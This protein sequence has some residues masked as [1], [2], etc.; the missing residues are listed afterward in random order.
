M[1]RRARQPRIEG[2]QAS[3]LTVW[4]PSGAVT[5]D[6][7]VVPFGVYAWQWHE[8]IRGIPATLEYR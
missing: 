3:R 6:W 7:T 8:Y 5:G 1:A 2:Y 4:W